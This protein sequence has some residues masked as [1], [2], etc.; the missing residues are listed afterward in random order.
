MTQPRSFSHTAFIGTAANVAGK[1][2]IVLISLVM[3][4]ITLNAVGAVDYGTWVLVGSIASFSFLLDVGISAG[5]VKYVAEHS[6]RGESREAALMIGAATWCYAGLGIAIASLGVIAGWLVP[7]L[8]ALDDET[9]RI[10]KWLAVLAA[11]DTG[12]TL[13]AIAPIAVLKAL[14]GSRA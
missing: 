5:L 3:V 11:L 7:D 14:H 2:I 8:L 6:T 12:V 4:P 9:R 10:V 13:P 1:A